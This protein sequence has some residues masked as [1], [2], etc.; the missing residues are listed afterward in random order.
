MAFVV[1]Q[2]VDSGKTLTAYRAL[3]KTK[4][5]LVIPPSPRAV[6]RALT[7]TPA[8]ASPRWAESGNMKH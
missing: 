4:N 7:P 6:P 5:Q 8:Q 2:K 1:N 3:A